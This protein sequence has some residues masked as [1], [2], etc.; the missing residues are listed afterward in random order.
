MTKL[1]VLE[2]NEVNFGTLERYIRQ[3]ELPHFQSFFLRHGYC[4]T[5]SEVGYTELEPWIQWVTA[6]TGMSF[7]K[8][9]IFRLGDA[10]E[11]GVPQIWEQL[12]MEHGV[13]AGAVS[14]M[15]AANRLNNAAFFV[16]DPWTPTQASGSWLLRRLSGAVSQTV[17]DN[18]ASRISPKSLFFLLLGALRYARPINYGTYLKLVAGVASRPWNK[19][20][21]LDLFL[22]DL[23]ISLTRA[24]QPGFC[25]LFVNG[26][27]HLQHHYLLNSPTVTGGQ[28]NPAWYV[29]PEADPVGDI[30][31]T[32][33]HILG[34]VMKGLPNYRVML[35]TGLHQ[36]PCSSP[37][38][39]WRPRD[40]ARMLTALG[41]AFAGV[42]PR[43]SRDFIVTFDN[44][45][46]LERTS[47]IL[48]AAHIDGTPAFQLEDRGKDIFVELFY[49][50]D[51]D[52]KS[53]MVSG[54]AEI[55]RLRDEVAFVALKNGVHNGV[56][57]FA[58]SGQPQGALPRSIP[59]TQVHQEILNIF[60]GNPT[61]VGLNS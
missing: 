11:S 59:L 61:S 53:T 30:Y 4:E 33:D 34:S 44:R 15:N 41:C 14:P 10:V 52:A 13:R 50:R 47:A 55:P 21:F 7:A 28:S 39:Y 3:G 40:H 25:T 37:I 36:D 58:D 45:E 32:Y 12:E 9:G 31:R 56:G 24:K 6:H 16:P 35:I 38:F 5:T 42:Q 22:S 18:A 19:V 17:N 8:H 60:G 1:A 48:K 29:K 26:A 27:A 46:D 54:A 43:M 2:L 57:Y 49:A 23:F 20:R 51:I